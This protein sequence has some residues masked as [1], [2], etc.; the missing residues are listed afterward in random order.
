MLNE[1]DSAL[2]DA[3]PLTPT[4]NVSKNAA[5]FISGNTPFFF[6]IGQ[7]GSS[8]SVYSGGN[9]LGS[10]TVDPA[11][12]WN[13]TSIGLGDGTPYTVYVVATDAAGATS[14]P[15]ANLSFGIDV[16]APA[17]PFGNLATDGRGN[18]SLNQPVF[19]GFADAG[20][21][22]DL[23]N[24]G[25]RI[26]FTI[27][28]ADGGWTLAPAALADGVYSV[29]VR[30]TD[31]ADNSSY[32]SAPLAFKL[33]S[34]LNRIGGPGNDML[35]GNP[36]NNALD[37][38]GGIDTAMPGGARAGYLLERTGT[39]F[40]LTDLDGGEGIDTLHNIERIHF[41]DVSVAIDLDGSGGQAFRLY[42]AAFDRAPEPAGVGYWI[43]QMDHGA[44]LHEVAAGFIASPEFAAL[45]GANP[46]NEQ[47][48]G[49]LYQN[50]LGRE[51]DAGGYDYW[52]GELAKPGVDRAAVLAAFSE[53][54]ENQAQL[55]GI[56][57]NGIEFLPYG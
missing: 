16:H 34:G 43:D 40:T 47:F 44:T 14:A 6:G 38:L 10:T 19:G 24:A 21:R 35:T 49:G 37:G 41:P 17:V 53:S 25:A 52:M 2:L 46:S 12:F 33:A 15:S 11:G 26:G 4:M 28:G 7:A 32:S 54:A 50:V 9:A 45:Y 13:L 48:I 57:V 55:I 42:Q 23:L 8:I 20:T 56:I 1:I 31:A 22:I 27:T 29:S 51:P 3:A 18:V 39:G 30:S 36:A 5:G